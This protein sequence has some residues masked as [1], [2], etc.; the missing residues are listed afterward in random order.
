MKAFKWALTA[1]LAISVMGPVKH[2][3]ADGK[4]IVDYDK[5]NMLLSD[6]TVWVD[7]PDDSGFQNFNYNLIELE[8][9]YGVSKD[10]S[11]IQ[12]YGSDAPK[13]VQDKTG[14]VQVSGSN[15]LKSDGTVWTIAGKQL[16]EYSDIAMIGGSGN[17]IVTLSRSGE[18]KASTGFGKKVAQF[19]SASEVVSIEAYGSSYSV[20]KILVVLSSGKV[21][22][23]K[24]F[25][26]DEKDLTK[27]IPI[28]LSEDGAAALFGSIGTVTVLLK[29]G[30]VWST[31]YSGSFSDAKLINKFPNLTGVTDLVTYSYYLILT[32]QDG[33]MLEYSSSNGVSKKILLPGLNDLTFTMDSTEFTVGDSVGVQIN[34]KWDRGDIK[35]IP[36]SQANMVIEKP[37]LLQ[38][39]ADGTLKAMAVGTTKVTVTSGSFSKTL[40]VTITSKYAIGNGAFI[41]GTMF[42]P[43]KSV[44]EQMGGT[45]QYNTATKIFSIQLQEHKI[46]LQTGSDTAI[47][48]GN[49]IKMPAVVQ[50]VDGAIV[51]PATLMKTGLGAEL[52]WDG[53]YQVMT[54][55]FGAAELEIQTKQTDLIIKKKAQGNLSKLIGKTYWINNFDSDYRFQK[56]TIADIIPDYKGYFVIS[57]KLSSGKIINSYDMTA[58]SVVDVLSSKDCFFTSDPTKLYKFSSSMWAKIKAGKISVGMTKQQV[59][60]SWGKPSDIATLTGGGVKVETWSFGNFNYV[61]FTN[62]LVSMIYTN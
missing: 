22:L 10:G 59:E 43:V 25:N 40:T 14:V 32:T 41:K 46:Q 17:S 1:V 55:Q 53:T 11:L 39:Q 4:N 16:T 49:K 38:K 20:D 23:Y 28:V 35:R 30:T 37:T 57:F 31:D 8:N 48:D 52:V 33:S 44:F 47:V 7:T 21:L 5:G 61:T 54:I 6:G 51:F 12:L 50:N 56:V 62:G 58:S 9:G 27:Y 19:S 15:F 45:V 36:L 42:I 18:L 2:A 24:K 60:L 3:H 34:E 13:V 26:F 29:D